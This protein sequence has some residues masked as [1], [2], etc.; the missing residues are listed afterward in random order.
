MRY[1][2]LTL[3][4][5][6]LVAAATPRV[7]ERGDDDDNQERICPSLPVRGGGCIRCINPPPHLSH[8]LLTSLD[9]R[10]FDVTGV[11]TEIDL[12]F[13]EIQ[14]KCDCISA[15]I[16]QSAT[17]NNYVWKFSTPDSVTSGYR[18]CTLCNPPAVGPIPNNF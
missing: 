1:S 15:C 5:L 13:P 11:T 12:T 10:G 2:L 4:S 6:L 17:C 18:T 3:V 14:D 7:V 8:T 9:V 16:A